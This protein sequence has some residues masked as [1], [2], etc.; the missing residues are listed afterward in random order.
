MRKRP[1]RE[2]C[3]AF[4]VFHVE[5]KMDRDEQKRIVKQQQ[6]GFKAFHRFEVSEWRKATFADRLRDYAAIMEFAELIPG[7]APVKP[8]LS[9]AERWNRIRARYNETH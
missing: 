9:V 1:Y 8:D 2:I 6:A 4:F 7:R 5:T 3:A